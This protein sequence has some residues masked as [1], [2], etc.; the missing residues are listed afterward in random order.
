[1]ST[2][3]LDYS[4]GRMSLTQAQTAVADG[5]RGAIRYIDSPSNLS[6]K[7]TDRAEYL[8]LLQAG[9]LVHLVMQTTVTASSGGWATGIDHATRARAG[10]DALGYS[11]PVFFTNDRTELPSVPVWRAYLDG[12]ASVL[13]LDRVGAYGFGNAMDA[14]QGHAACFWQAGSRSQ[15]RP[16]VNFWQDNTGYVNVAGIT[17]DRNL[18][19]VPI[20]DSVAITPDEIN[21]I[22][23]AVEG[24]FWYGDRFYDPDGAGPAPAE[25]WAQFQQRLYQRE[26]D[27]LAKLDTVLAQLDAARQSILT[28]IASGQPLTQAQVEAAFT[29]AL[30]VLKITGDFHAS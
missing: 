3:Y 22:A 12:A 7:H 8:N 5:Y 6:A 17:C 25:N 16:F 29:A 2:Y 30:P 27:I 11:G 21:Q 4:S 23:A 1:M 14:A 15:L 28:A 9:L 13:G 20:G 24:R 19:Q 26:A 18:V 10:A